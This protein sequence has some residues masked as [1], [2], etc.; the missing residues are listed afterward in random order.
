MAVVRIRPASRDE[1]GDQ[2]ADDDTYS[3][4]ELAGAFTAPRTSSDTDG[5]ARDGAVVGLTLFLPAGAD[6]VRTD[7]IEVDDVR[8][9]IDGDLADWTSPLTGWAPGL[10][11]A[12]VRA[13]G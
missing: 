2:I 12:L 4:L 8:Y 10:T 7:L 9:R 13:E 3:D 6:V 1:Y 5:P 11:A